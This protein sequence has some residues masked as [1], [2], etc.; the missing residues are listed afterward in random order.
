MSV[1]S[2]PFVLV[3]LVFLAIL[4]TMMTM[5]TMMT[6]ITNNKLR[7]N[8]SKVHLCVVA[9]L[10]SELCSTGMKKDQVACI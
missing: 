9:Q 4:M 7:V 3:V 5:K 1:L 10:K 8:S 2:V 6:M